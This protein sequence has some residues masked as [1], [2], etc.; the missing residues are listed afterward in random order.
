M[1]NVLAGLAIV[2][3]V[4]IAITSL[5][6]TDRQRNRDREAESERR[7]QE[8]RFSLVASL[9]PLLNA[10]SDRVP[11]PDADDGEVEGHLERLRSP[12]LKS[13]INVLTFVGLVFPSPKAQFGSGT[14]QANVDNAIMLEDMA[15]QSTDV[16]VRRNYLRLANE[17]LSNTVQDLRDL[18]RQVRG[19]LPWETELSPTH[20]SAQV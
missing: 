5:I 2:A 3:S 11:G 7:F 15:L 4:V 17:L 14:V 12:E 20:P 8:W 10:L 19:P 1:D 16:E 9:V 13:A 18:T 6:V